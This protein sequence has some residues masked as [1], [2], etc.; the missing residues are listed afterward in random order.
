MELSMSSARDTC[1]E[2]L[3]GLDEDILEYLI[4]MLEGDEDQETM[5][6]AVAEFLLSCEHCATEDEATTKCRELFAALSSVGMADPSPAD[7]SVPR[8]LES[9]TSLA[10]Q[11]AALFREG[12]DSGLGGRLVDL[13]EALDSRKKRKRALGPRTLRYR[14]PFR[15][16]TPT[17]SSVDPTPPACHCQSRARRAQREAELRAVRNAH[18]R[19]VAQREAEETALQDALTNAV[20]LRRQM[21]AYTGAVEAKPFSL[22]NPGGG[23][24]LLEN[25][26]FTLTRGRIYALIGRNGKGKSTLLKALARREVRGGTRVEG[27]GR[28]VEGGGCRV[29][30]VGCRV[31]GAGC[32]V[33]GA[34]CWVLDRGS[35]IEDRGSRE[36]YGSTR[37][38][39]EVE[40]CLLTELTRATSVYGRWATFRQS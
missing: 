13:D 7:S 37:E 18:A 25:A 15:L 17:P 40:C 24:D 6:V 8:M 3:Q 39:S 4:A 12:D 31:L 20:T 11:D 33:P 34:G 16:T 1:T 27:G 35:R 32:R 22:A 38:R 30:G 26:S 5:E 9:K 23:R 21:G 19:I 29:Q 10:E 28:R 36:E 2:L 14:S